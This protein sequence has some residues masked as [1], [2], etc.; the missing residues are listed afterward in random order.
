MPFSQKLDIM[1]RRHAELSDY[2][3]Q[4]VTM[5]DPGMFARMSKEYAELDPIVEA[6][7]SLHALEQQMRETLDLLDN[8]ESDQDLREMVQEERENLKEQLAEKQRFIQRLLLPQ[9]PND[10]KMLFWKFVLEL[11]ATRP[12]CLPPTC[13]ACMAATLKRVVGVWRLSTAV[14]RPWVALRRW[15]P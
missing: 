15:L 12:D 2:L 4:A 7:N 14:L 1:A 8:S 13:S 10:G 6:R 3:A 11:A 9:D 5:T